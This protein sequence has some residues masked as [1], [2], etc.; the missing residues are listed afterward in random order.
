[1]KSSRIQKITV[2]LN[3]IE[4]KTVRENADRNQISVSE[5]VRSLVRQKPCNGGTT[6]PPSES[7]INNQATEKRYTRKTNGKT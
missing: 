1:M 5:Y 2:R 4:N 7:I 3:E 6:T